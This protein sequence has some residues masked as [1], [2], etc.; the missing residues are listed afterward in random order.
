MIGDSTPP[1]QTLQV[2][3][4]LS[5][6]TEGKGNRAGSVV[7]QPDRDKSS[8]ARPF[9]SMLALA[10]PVLLLLMMHLNLRRALT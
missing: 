8:R 9:C 10:K 1:S 3:D 2:M 7:T 5:S 6:P 4:G